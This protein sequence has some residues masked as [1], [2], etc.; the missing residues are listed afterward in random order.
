MSLFWGLFVKSCLI[1]SWSHSSCAKFPFSYLSEHT[2]PDV[3]SLSNVISHHW[4]KPACLSLS[5]TPLVLSRYIC[6]PYVYLYGSEEH[7]HSCLYIPT[8]ERGA[9]ADVD[10][11]ISVRHIPI[12][13]SE[14]LVFCNFVTVDKRMLL[15]AT[16]TRTVAFLSWCEI[17]RCHSGQYQPLIHTVWYRDTQ[18]ALSDKRN[19]YFL[20]ITF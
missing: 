6:W 5:H 16:V 17:V 19:N 15:L 3:T 20:P 13:S 7:T 9:P 4:A 18:L 2:D 8:N 10:D 14:I 12:Y 11:I 1:P